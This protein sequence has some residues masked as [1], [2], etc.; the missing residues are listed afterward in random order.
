MVDKSLKNAT[1]FTHQFC[2]SLLACLKTR[3]FVFRGGSLDIGL[4]VSKVV[5]PM[6]P[7]LRQSPL[8]LQ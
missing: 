3:V 8:L 1:K 2:V 7:T 4:S 6:M 5:V